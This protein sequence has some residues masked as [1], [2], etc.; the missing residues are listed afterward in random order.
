MDK[1]NKTK[2]PP[3][4]NTM[5]PI[6]FHGFPCHGWNPLDPTEDLLDLHLEKWDLFGALGNQQKTRGLNKVEQHY[7]FICLICF[8]MFEKI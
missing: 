3:R 1:K 5:F 2:T 6:A 4:N 7:F 8:G